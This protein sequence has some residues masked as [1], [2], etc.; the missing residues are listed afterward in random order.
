MKAS[1]RFIFA[2]LLILLS[3][4]CVFL[5]EKDRPSKP[6]ERPDKVD[7][8]DSTGTSDGKD[9]L[10]AYPCRINLETLSRMGLEPE[11]KHADIFVYGSELV[12]YERVEGRFCDFVLHEA[13][14]YFV[15]AVANAPGEFHPE[16]LLH[17]DSWRGLEMLL[18]YE[19]PE[20]AIMRGTGSFS[21][22]K[23]LAA[24]AAENSP[25]LA[26]V[27]LEPLLC[28]VQISSITQYYDG[29]ILVENPRI[30]LE[31]CCTRAELFRDEGF[32]CLDPSESKTTYLPYDIGLY[33]QYPGTTI[34]CYPNDMP[35][36]ETSPASV[37]VLDYE[38]LGQSRQL[39]FPIH[40]LRRNSIFPLDVNIR[41]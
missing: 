34:Y 15:M 32:Y 18:E 14:E 40:P 16:V 22:K 10:R 19:K 37:L 4:A 33:T 30:H 13:G 3:G 31:N 27:V 17:T 6:D 26:A 12:H 41:P 2:A 21:V 11:L 35:Q 20:Q 24:T 7:E 23:E 9:T 39:R 8:P 29:D 36:S 25:L 38:V 5:P 28:G 1:K